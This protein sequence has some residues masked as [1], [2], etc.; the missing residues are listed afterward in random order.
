[1]GK[2]IAIIDI[3]SSGASTSYANIISIAG[4]LVN[5]ELEE[6]DRFELYCRNKPGHVPDPYSMWVN[7]GLTRMK[8][9]NLN[10]YSMMIELHKYISKWS[11]CVWTGW[12]SIGFDFVMLQK[13]NYRSLFPIYRTN[14]NGNEHSDFLPVARASKHFYPDCI[15][16]NFSE[17][18]NP[19]FRLDSIGPL[20]FA[21]LNKKKLHTAI[22]DCETCLEVM[23]LLKKNANS[24]FESSK[25]TTAKIDA[26]NEMEKHKIFTT[27][28][29]FYGRARPYIVTY[30]CDHGKY[31]WPMV[32]CLE[33]E[34]NDLMTLDSKSL[35]ESL[36][37]PGKWLRALPLKHP[38][39]LSSSFGLKTDMYKSIGMAKLTERANVL[40]TNK[41]FA[42]KVS[43][44][45]GEIA[46]EKENSKKA[47]DKEKLS[48]EDS[49]FANGFPTTK[50]QN[51]MQA[52]QQTDDWQKKYQI[53][54]KI[55]DPRFIYF[56][57]RLIY[58]ND[59]GALPKKEYEQIHTDIAKKILNPEETRFTTVVSAE[60][61][62]D[63]IRAEKNIS[64]DKLDYINEV[65]EFVQKIRQTYEKAL[66]T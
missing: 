58:Q 12:N 2:N 38:I 40:K 33:T 42:R 66:H 51:T 23:R 10:H 3:E 64:Q 46:Q 31:N 20:N 63:D 50:D 24:I 43:V 13:E 8:N 7:K 1:M 57:K 61:L 59:P 4:I 65:D 55:E 5:P 53:I 47:K 26:K 22:G 19:I 56:G 49:L 44:A 6:L 41:E 35:K 37:K 16:T 28:F 48:H 52:F 15:K 25:K 32:Y 9:S 54:S 36:K 17:K 39:I 29:Y 45:L 27:M 34:P 14:Q 30:L 60:K 21:N 18:S 62:I 11:P